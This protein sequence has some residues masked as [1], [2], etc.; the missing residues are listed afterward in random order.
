M[1]EWFLAIAR[2]YQPTPIQI[3][4]GFAV[5]LVMALWLV[6]VVGDW[7]DRRQA[8][9]DSVISPT[10]LREHKQNER[11]EFHGVTWQQQYLDPP[12]NVRPFKSKPDV[13]AMDGSE[14]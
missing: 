12:S 4:A 13:W 5:L 9:K 11:E 10:W 14:R 1:T 2:A 3:F 8:R 6:D 7:W